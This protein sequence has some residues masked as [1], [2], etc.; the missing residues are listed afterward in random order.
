MK[1]NYLNLAKLLN[2]YLMFLGG[3]QLF[4][5]IVGYYYLYR[6]IEIINWFWIFICLLFFTFSL[7]IGIVM[8]TANREKVIRYAKINLLMQTVQIGGFGFIY[9][10]IAGVC[11]IFGYKEFFFYKVYLVISELNIGY[12][13]NDDSTIIS[14]NFFPVICLFFLNILQRKLA[15]RNDSELSSRE[16]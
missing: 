8:L 2:P 13:S 14:I 16:E 10:Y 3:Y 15:I 6:D 11:L 12:F 9:T 4:G 5:A 7:I 1:P